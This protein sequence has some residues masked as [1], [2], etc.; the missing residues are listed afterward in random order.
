M[1][2][3]CPKCNTDNRAT[4]KFCDSG[5]APLTDGAEQ[6]AEQVVVPVANPAGGQRQVN[7][8]GLLTIVAIL[9]FVGWLIFGPNAE[10]N[11]VQAGG[12]IGQMA[13]PHGAAQPEGQMS[14][15]QMAE[16]MEQ[17]DAAKASLDQDPLD[18]EALQT[19]YLA[20]GKIDRQ[21]QIRPRLDAAV[22]ALVAKIDDI[23]PEQLV[24]I[25]NS[26][27]Y[28][29]LFGHDLEGAEQAITTLAEAAPDNLGILVLR[30][31]I[32]YDLGLIDQSIAAYTAYL[33]LVDPES[34]ADE[35]WNARTDRAT[36]M[37]QHGQENDDLKMTT[38]ALEEFHLV[39]QNRPEFYSA[40]FNLGLA[41]MAAK[42]TAQAEA[43]WVSAQAVA[44]TERE[45]YRVAKELAILRGE[46]PPPLPPNMIPPAMDG[47][48]NPH[49][50]MDM[51]TNAGGMPN[52]AQ[53]QTA[54]VLGVIPA[55]YSSTRFPGKPLADIAGKSLIQRV[56]EQASACKRLDSVLVA[57]DDQR[58]YQHVQGFG[59]QVVMTSQS[60]A[61][62]TDRLGQVAEKH[63][64]G[65]YVNIQGDE[66]LLTPEAIDDLV[67]K[68][69]AAKAQMSTLVTPLDSKTDA[70]RIA[71]P[72]VVKA[73]LDSQGYALYFSRS[74]IPFNRDAA[75]AK[76]FKHIGIYMYSH[77]TLHNMCRWERTPLEIAESLE[78]LRAL[79]N[80][81][82]ILCV[83][84]DYDPAGVDTPDDIARV[85]KSLKG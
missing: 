58:I 52:P 34:A 56:W 12:D 64:A 45:E 37:L 40:W 28:S 15:A 66:P 18:L 27:A 20:F 3:A 59:G 26:M 44:T 57:T 32:Y 83:S 16:M 1:A 23:T 69:L 67:L 76:Y 43:A 62:G 30:G 19:L 51:G 11:T 60:H 50:G 70:G 46:A 47:M 54:L 71:D 77:E 73:V 17:L 38:K 36:M 7:V 75:E 39:T 8:G 21:D 22:E 6:V 42:E 41:C 79:E 65:Y 74:V 49:G 29:A 31:N 10:V 2:L 68:T 24:K 48:A 63:R 78:Q 4:A 81:V 85:V 35:Y 33:D 84:S 53:A 14:E 80:G 61:S 9:S 82:N 55:R 25:L 13:N 5:G 72:N